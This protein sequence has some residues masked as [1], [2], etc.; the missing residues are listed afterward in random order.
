E[1]VAVVILKWSVITRRG[2]S[3]NIESVTDN[4]EVA[5]VILKWSLITG[6][7]GS[8]NMER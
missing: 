6:R 3:G 4:K 7:G 1:E 8:G 5:V 2:G